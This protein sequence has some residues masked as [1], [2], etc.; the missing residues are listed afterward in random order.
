MKLCAS[1]QVQWWQT[2]FVSEIATFAKPQT[3][4]GNFM[5]TKH[6]YDNSGKLVL[7]GKITF[8]TTSVLLDSLTDG[9]YHIHVGSNEKKSFTI[10]KG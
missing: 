2:V 9:M 1:Y 3:V 6:N 7:S 5:T 10:I 8:E 4:S